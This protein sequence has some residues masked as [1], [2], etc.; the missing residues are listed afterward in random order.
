[1]KTENLAYNFTHQIRGKVFH[2]RA[3]TSKQFESYF[4]STTHSLSTGI[5]GHSHRIVPD[6]RV[7]CLIFPP[8]LALRV[9]TP[10]ESS[11]QAE[12]V[13]LRLSHTQKWLQ[14]TLPYLTKPKL[15]TVFNPTSCYPDSKK[16]YSYTTMPHC[17]WRWEWLRESQSGKG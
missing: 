14:T 3:S 6:S 12:R 11:Q 9:A 8:S 7:F 15:T 17:S 2:K 4:S 1:M 13:F 16:A 10:G 5:V